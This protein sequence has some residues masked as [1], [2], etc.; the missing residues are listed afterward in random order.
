L[1]FDEG[2]LEEVDVEDAADAHD[3]AVGEDIEA[4]DPLEDGDGQ[5][6][7]LAD[8]AD[9][10]GG[11]TLDALRGTPAAFDARIHAVRPHPGQQQ[12][13]RNLLRMNEGSEI[14]ES[15]RSLE[16]DPRIQDAYSLRC[17]P[18]V[19]GAARDAVAH[20]RRVLEIEL[21]SAT[22]NPLIFAAG[23]GVGEVLSGGN[24]HGQ[25]V[26][27]A[28]DFLAL[29]LQTLAGISE[30]RTERLVNPFLNEG[31]PAFLAS[32]PGLE[33]G[34]MTPQVVAAALVS[35]NKV[36]AHPASADS[37]TTSG[38]KEDFVSMGP[39]AAQK[40]MQI[41]ENAEYLVA[42]ELLCAAQAMEFRGPEKLGKGT[43]T[44]YSTLRE[45]V[46][47]LDEDRTLSE[48]IEKI[49]LIVRKGTI[50]DEIERS[51]RAK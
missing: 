36:L 3:A 8:T 15:H 34:F 12:S 46:P 39:I 30:R 31:L 45:A 6:E 23:P 44:V 11:L 2:T 42:I 51:P 41:L 25:P 48:D 7:I 50:L 1:D 19:H 10:I 24:F 28:L 33:S 40:A 5:A 17:M 27:L 9:V 20:V 49:R 14:R 35:E 47:K 13:A 21:N 29:A 22:D 32:E 43:R 37:I 18:Q 4:G 26:A 16:A 38:N